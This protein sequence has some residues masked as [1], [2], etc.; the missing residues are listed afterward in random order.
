LTVAKAR[1]FFDRNAF[2]LGTKQNYILVTGIKWYVSDYC[3]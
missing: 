1:K 3:F 2:V